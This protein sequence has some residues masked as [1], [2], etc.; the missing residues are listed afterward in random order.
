MF[1]KEPIQAAAELNQVLQ[2]T[3]KMKEIVE[4][5]FKS[6][7]HT[8]E[9]VVHNAGEIFEKNHKKRLEKMKNILDINL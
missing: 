7:C 3:R 4:E 2:F 1:S 8:R 9:N 5:I 6:H